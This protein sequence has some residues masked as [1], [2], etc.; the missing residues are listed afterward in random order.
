MAARTRNARSGSSPASIEDVSGTCRKGS[1]HFNV[2]E[3]QLRD[4]LQNVRDGATDVES[5]LQQVKHM[6]FE[7]LGFAKVDHHR[8]LRHGI[9]EVVFGLGKTPD[10]VSAIV[11]KLAAQ[12]P[13]V[14]VTR[15]T[16]DTAARLRQ[17]HPD[18]EYFPASG[19]VRLWRD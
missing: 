1:Y 9:P 3:H 14:L 15:A 19:A 2:T 11:S 10:Q 7:D 12:S 8:A 17:E 13:N 18:A 5:A 6:P 16:P 4:L